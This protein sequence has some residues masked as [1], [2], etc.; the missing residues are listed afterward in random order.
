MLEITTIS[1]NYVSKR[2][3]KNS[4]RI[5]KCAE[6]ID[7]K[8]F[9][10]AAIIAETAKAAA[11]DNSVLS[12]DGFKN[13]H[14][15]T[16]AAFGFKKSMSYS[17]LKIGQNFTVK[18]GKYRCNLTTEDVNGIEIYVN[19]TTS[20][21]FQMLSFDEVMVRDA[22]YKK[23]ITAEMSCREIAKKLKEIKMAISMAEAAEAAEAAE[24]TEAAE[25]EVVNNFVDVWDSEGVCFHVPHD[26]LMQYIAEEQ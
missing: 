24:E 23:L 14:E 5:L 6:S 21:V 11:E 4:Q 15:W 22:V 7:S 20:Q 26:I 8:M 3:E 13:V 2:L 17:L 10:V 25:T 12:E 18:D 16:E 19:F 1:R 9:E